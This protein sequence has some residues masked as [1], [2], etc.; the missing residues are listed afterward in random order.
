M[1]WLEPW[2]HSDHKDKMAKPEKR[3]S[4][5]CIMMEAEDLLQVFKAA[6]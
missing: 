5:P 3:W 6:K 1:P 2:E 4:Q